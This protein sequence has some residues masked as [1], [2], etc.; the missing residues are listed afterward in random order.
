MENL[1][2]WAATLLNGIASTVSLVNTLVIFTAFIL[3]I[4]TGI[5]LNFKN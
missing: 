3:I 1:K 2:T 5:M 4:S